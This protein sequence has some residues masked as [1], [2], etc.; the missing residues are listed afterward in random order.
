MSLLKT[1][2]TT[3]TAMLL[4]AVV[5]VAAFAANP[6]AEMKVAKRGTILIELRPD[7]APKTV[8]HFVE[9]VNKKF[10]DGILFHRYVDGFVIQAGD[11]NS[12]KYATK[13]LSDITAEEVGQRFRLGGGGSGK[14]VPLEAKGS[15]TEG[16]VGLARSSQP[17]SGDS[18]F[19]FNL[20][21]NSKLDTMMGGYCMFGKVVKGA[22]V[23]MKLRQGDKIESIRIVKAKPTPKK[24]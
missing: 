12:K 11:P 17:D 7:Y 8:A 23:M 20:A 19:F 14:S 18:Q 16:T 9:L 3:L 10:Y 1:T 2:L 24:K 4:T 22:D 6:M 13:D 5:S 21:D 15:N